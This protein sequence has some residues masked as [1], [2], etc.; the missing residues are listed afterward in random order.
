MAR[1]IKLAVIVARRG[2]VGSWRDHC[3][4]AGS[5]QWLEDAFI[6]VECFVGDQ[7]IGRYRGQQVIGPDQIVCLAAAQEEA[8]R[9][10]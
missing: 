5:G 4:L 8:D 1:R 7:R 6:G 9:V 3:D 10:A 2:P